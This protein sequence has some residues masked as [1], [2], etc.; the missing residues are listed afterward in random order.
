MSLV[1]RSKR[2]Q[3]C[4][5]SLDLGLPGLVWSC[6]PSVMGENRRVRYLPLRLFD[7][8]VES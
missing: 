3:V 8:S 5:E 4:P 1:G 7:V 2:T 6:S